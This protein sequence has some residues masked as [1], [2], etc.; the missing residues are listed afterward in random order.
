MSVGFAAGT[1]V[2]QQ[3]QQCHRW[4]PAIVGA[5]SMPRV[6]QPV[7]VMDRRSTV[8]NCDD[9]CRNS[10]L[11]LLVWSST[12]SRNHHI[13]ATYQTQRRKLLLQVQ[14]AKQARRASVAFAAALTA[15]AF[16]VTAYQT[17][18]SAA[19]L[20]LLRSVQTGACL[21]SNASGNAY[22][23]PCSSGNNY[24]RWNYYSGNYAI[25]FQNYATGR[26]LDSNLSGSAYT[27]PCSA[28]NAYQ[29]WQI[30]NTSG[31]SFELQDI[32][33]GKCLQTDG[34][35][36]VFTSSCNVGNNAQRWVFA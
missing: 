6:E 34:T 19:P 23:N 26:C 24:Q 27:N 1:G 35:G 28:G 21:D 30:V 7:T 18:A 32:A 22:T 31:S 11:N 2:A 25:L 17:P 8:A 36:A 16:G 4:K 13:K 15:T 10:F 33:T 29:N 5:W 20:P 12:I 9:I 3:L 14:G